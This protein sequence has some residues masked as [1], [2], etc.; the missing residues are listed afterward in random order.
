MTKALHNRRGGK[1]GKPQPAPGTPSKRE[2]KQLHAWLSGAILALGC[3]SLFLPLVTNTSFYYPFLFLKS[4]LFR[5]AVQAMTLLYVILAVVY[6]EFRPR[7]NRLVG[8]LLAYFGVMALSSLP[9]I[10]VAA[11]SSWWGDF[12]RMGGM[13]SKLHVL[14]YCLVLAHTLRRERQWIVLFTASLFFGVLMGLTGMLQYLKL[15]FLN[16]SNPL[17]RIRGATGN[18]TWFASLMLLN[19]FIAFWFLGRRGKQEAYELAA[20]WWLILLAAYDAFL[21]FL[22][23]WNVGSGPGILFTGLALPPVLIFGVVLHAVSLL[24][25]FLRRSVLAGT[26]FLIILSGYYLFWLYASETRGAVVGLVGSLAALSV[27]YTFTGAG[28]RVRW[29]GVAL[30][31]LVIAVPSVIWVNRNSSWVQSRSALQRFTRI[32]TEDILAA[33]FWAWKASGLAVLDRPILGWGLEN[34][35]L[36]FDLHFPPQIINPWEPMPWF[37]RAHNIILDVGTTTGF[38]GLSAFLIFY[39]LVFAFLL[40]QWFRTKDPTN[41][42]LIAALVL[43]YLLQALA[44][45]DTINTHVIVYLALAYILWLYR[46]DRGE[47]PKEPLAPPASSPVSTGGWLCIGASM[48]VLSAAFW[49]LVRNP[50]ESN[51]LLNQAIQYSKEIDPRTKVSKILYGQG[52][53]DMYHS[54]NDYQTMGRYRVRE[55]LANYVSELIGASDVPQLEKL[56]AARQAI[57]LLQQS[58]QQEP[59]NARNYL[60]LASLVNR[61]IPLI[62]ASD[63]AEASSLVVKNL[64]LLKKAEQLSPTRPQLYFEMARTLG[65]LGRFKEQA[66][67]IEK[68]MSLNPPMTGARYGDPVIKEPNLDLFLAYLAAGNNAAAAKQWEKIKSLSI[69]LTRADYEQIIALYASKKQFEPMVRL[70]KEQ[71]AATPNDAQLLAQLATTYRETGEL[72]LARE[73]ALKAASLAP[74]SQPAVQAFLESLKTARKA[75]Y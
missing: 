17:E 32:S 48:A 49:F 30:L 9:G 34:Y 5:A 53:L 59:R 54:A 73:T 45:F 36:G 7:L 12:A 13:F 27:L 15:D 61:S 47:L 14:A 41:S 67:A 26:I 22:E 50:Y 8:A 29:I 71:L 42:L 69:S 72:E 70:Y 24:W 20:K 16:K 66:A 51:L 38:V 23:V 52:L 2:F 43:A 75:N 44:T 64:E 21:V 56:R 3:F 68:G 58:V 35:S 39:S 10:S 25:F 1:S 4:M 46:H 57:A 11:W 33:R 37:D 31:L 40:R 62:R 18:A 74:Q 63:P 60:Y 28:R 6:P 19:F 55:E 65:L